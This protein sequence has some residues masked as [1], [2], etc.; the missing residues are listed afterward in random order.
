[1]R[2]SSPAIVSC[3]DWFLGRCCFFTIR[4]LR[5]AHAIAGL[6]PQALLVAA[7][8]RDRL[9]RHALSTRAS[10]TALARYSDSATL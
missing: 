7:D 8:H 3:T 9:S 10:F 4:V 5:L 6:H 2:A 1:M